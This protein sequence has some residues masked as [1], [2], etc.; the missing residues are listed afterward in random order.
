MNQISK[1]ERNPQILSRLDC[2]DEAIFEK[3]KS[4]ELIRWSD[5]LNGLNISVYSR[6]CSSV[7]SLS[8]NKGNYSTK[9]VSCYI[10]HPYKDVINLNFGNRPICLDFVLHSSKL[11]WLNT[12]L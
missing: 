10:F 2:R 8:S 3:F 6:M 4:K 9:T 5:T 12:W 7:N 1:D 11:G